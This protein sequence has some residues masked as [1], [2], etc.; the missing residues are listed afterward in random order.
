MPGGWYELERHVKGQWVLDAV[1]DDK[2][3][4]ISEAER[5][6]EGRRALG[7][8]V[9]RVDDGDRPPQTVFR[10]SLVDGH[11]R[12]ALNKRLALQEQAIVARKKRREK[13]S[14]ASS[15][16]R[17]VGARAIR[18]ARRLAAFAALGVALIG[19]VWWF[20]Q[21]AARGGAPLPEAEYRGS[22]GGYSGG[23]PVIHW[24]GRR[25]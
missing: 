11:N 10:K 14:A 23:G 2:E 1:F 17:Q 22:A 13:V 9:V 25:D 16:P 4:A 21:G 24:G 3:L 19:A 12:E 15:R 20:W 7:A 8:R 5:L 6:L 18:A